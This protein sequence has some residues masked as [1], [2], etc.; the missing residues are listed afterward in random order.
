MKQAIFVLGMLVGV[1]M[2]SC[3][4]P[5]PEASPFNREP[6]TASYS[7]LQRGFPCQEDEYL[8][9]HVRFGPDKVGCI[10]LDEL[11]YTEVATTRPPTT[12]G[13]N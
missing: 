4:V 1:A 2:W 11:M 3:Q 12:L 8:G 6:L 7:F 10:H 13:G 9:F 5:A